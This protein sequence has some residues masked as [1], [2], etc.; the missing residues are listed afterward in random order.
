MIQKQSLTEEVSIPKEIIAK[1][2]GNLEY[3]MQKN[4]HRLETGRY[5][6]DTL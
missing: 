4:F 3:R 6:P 2:E 5:L 1:V